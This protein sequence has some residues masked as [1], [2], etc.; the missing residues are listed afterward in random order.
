M[1]GDFNFNVGNMHLYHPHPFFLAFFSIALTF[2]EMNIFCTEFNLRMF[3]KRFSFFL[4]FSN[5]YHPVSLS[6]CIALNFVC[7][8]TCSCFIKKLK[9]DSGPANLEATMESCGDGE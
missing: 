4:R 2:E 1:G 7:K 8:L 3:V 9:L 5:S 6:F